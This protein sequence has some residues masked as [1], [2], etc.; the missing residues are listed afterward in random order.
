MKCRTSCCAVNRIIP[1]YQGIEGNETSDKLTKAAKRLFFE[2]IAVVVCKIV[3][4]YSKQ[5]I[6]KREYNIKSSHWQ[7]ISGTK[8]ANALLSGTPKLAKL[9]F[10]KWNFGLLDRLYDPKIP[11]TTSEKKAENILCECVVISR[12]RHQRSLLTPTEV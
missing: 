7:I 9:S 4:H 10:S 1:I 6:N 2:L 3:T 8:Q 11:S 5:A 12:T